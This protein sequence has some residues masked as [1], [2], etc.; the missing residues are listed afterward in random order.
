MQ[1]LSLLLRRHFLS[2]GRVTICLQETQI[3]ASLS[4]RAQRSIRTCF[5]IREASI[6]FGRKSW[7]VIISNPNTDDGWE[8]ENRE[9]TPLILRG[10]T[11]RDFSQRENK[12]IVLKCNYYEKNTAIVETKKSHFPQAQRNDWVFDY[13]NELLLWSNFLQSIFIVHAVT[14]SPTADT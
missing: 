14:W 3:T 6:Q 5:T 2:L 12:D 8:I 10:Q 4:W 9:R 13:G 11:W 1:Q 7:N